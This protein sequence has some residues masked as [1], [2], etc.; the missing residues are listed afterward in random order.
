MGTVCAALCA[1]PST[2]CNRTFL[3][4]S[5]CLTVLSWFYLGEASASTENQYLQVV[6]TLI[7]DACSLND[8]LYVM[9]LFQFLPLHGL[10]RVLAVLSLCCSHCSNTLGFSDKDQLGPTLWLH[11]RR[12]MSMTSAESSPC[13]TGF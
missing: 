8:P 6:C 11:R 10:E 4:T 7:G 13:C 12:A 5:K 2:S 3:F 1:W 9:K